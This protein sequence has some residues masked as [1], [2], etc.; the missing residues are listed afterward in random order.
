MSNYNNEVMKLENFH[1]ATIIEVLHSDWE[2]LMD[3]IT[4]G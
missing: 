1:L 3:A 2:M 4:S